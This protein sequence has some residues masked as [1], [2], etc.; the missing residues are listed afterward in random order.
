M[1]THQ[2][3]TLAA[4]TECH[5]AIEPPDTALHCVDPASQ[6]G[7]IVHVADAT[8]TQLLQGSI[9]EHYEIGSNGVGKTML[10]NNIAHQALIAGHTVLCTVAGQLLGD[11]TA[12]ESDAGLRRR[13][14]KYSA[15]DVLVIDEI[16]YLSYSNRHADL[17]FE[18]L[19]RRYEKKST[20]SPPINRSRNGRKCSL[21]PAAS[22]RSS[23]GSCTAPKLLPSR[24]SR[25][26]SKK[27]KN[28]RIAT[29]A[30]GARP[31]HQSRGHLR[32]RWPP[33]GGQHF[34]HSYSLTRRRFFQQP[35]NFAE[36]A[37]F[38]SAANRCEAHH[39]SGRFGRRRRDTL[40][41]FAQSSRSRR[42]FA[43]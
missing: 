19:N 41:A 4:R 38:Y 14:R 43:A 37:P 39:L 12:T 15:P 42:Y 11:L 21:T 5:P 9:Y 27:P 10:A 6:A 16:G 13:L 28:G 24:A 2:S 3:S 23:I 17:L 25:T 7:A 32:H 18:L 36:Y 31:S 34:Q 20:T 8:D 35:N 29:N 40:A 30:G 33:P 26:A 1:L 22:F